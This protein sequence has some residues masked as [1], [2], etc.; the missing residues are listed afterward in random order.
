[1]FTFQSTGSYGKSAA[2]IIYY[3]SAAF[4]A[5]SLYNIELN[6]WN[7]IELVYVGIVPSFA[8]FHPKGIST[9]IQLLVV[10][11]P[12]AS[13]NTGMVIVESVRDVRPLVVGAL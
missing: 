10:G 4:A 7:P 6:S 11:V 13:P 12:S 1:M 3:K 2:R 5:T 9:Y 8:T